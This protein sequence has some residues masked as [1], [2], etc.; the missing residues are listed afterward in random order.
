MNPSAER[1]QLAVAPLDSGVAPV[2]AV[3][4]EQDMGQL[5]ATRPR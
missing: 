2:A 5:L 3:A 1:P 4:V